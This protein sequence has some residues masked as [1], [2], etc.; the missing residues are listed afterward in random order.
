M[1]RKLCLTIWLA[2]LLSAAPA[3]AAGDIYVG[4]PYGTKITSLPYTISAPG[5]YYLAGNLS[6]S[7]A[8]GNGI[9]INSDHVTLDL[10]GFAL[11]YSGSGTN[12]FGIYLDQANNV[13]IRNGT[14]RG[15]EYGIHGYDTWPLTIGHRIINVRLEGNL[16]AIWLAGYGH[17]IKGCQANAGNPGQGDAFEAHAVMVTGC[18]AENFYRGIGFNDGISCGNVLRNIV[19]GI[20]PSSGAALIMG[21]EI[22]NTVIGVHFH[23]VASIIGNIIKTN[24]DQTGI[25]EYV[26]SGDP[27]N[28]FLLDQNTVTGPGTH[29]EIS[30][31]APLRNNAGYP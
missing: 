14:I 22:S 28:I 31:G 1:P 17:L 12:N 3:L 27:P 9:T 10:R 20:Y 30:P 4:G 2:V 18:L 8:T 25:W 24:S 5:A 19:W 16:N 7:G 11:T 29:Y 23:N 21:N 26:F 13:E 6:Y 15:W